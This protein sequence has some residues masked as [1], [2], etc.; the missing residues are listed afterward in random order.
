M[1]QPT[2]SGGPPANVEP[3]DLWAKLTTLPRPHTE[4]AFPRRHPVTKEWFTDKVAIRVLTESELMKARA[5]SDAYAKDLLGHKAKRDDANSSHNADVT[6]GL[7][8][9]QIYNNACIVEVLWLACRSAINLP[10]SLGVPAFP[11][12][13]QMRQHFTS[14]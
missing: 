3:A 7:A 13:Q 5:A 4:V 12:T 8:Y 2:P 6:G 11:S 10:Q 9:P 14:D 1:I